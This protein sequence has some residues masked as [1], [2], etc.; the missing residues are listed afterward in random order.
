[1]SQQI[2][3]LTYF[4]HN[5][6]RNSKKTLSRML[7]RRT[8]EGPSEYP[9]IIKPID[10]NQLT[11][12]DVFNFIGQGLELCPYGR[13]YTINRETQEVYGTCAITDLACPRH[14][15]DPIDKQGCWHYNVLWGKRDLVQKADSESS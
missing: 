5:R 3:G 11:Q 12:T 8:P 6:H 9:S 10:K 15:A 2:K 14:R 4:G 13:N 1:M 7:K